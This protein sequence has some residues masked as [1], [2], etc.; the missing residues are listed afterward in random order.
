MDDQRGTRKRSCHDYGLLTAAGWEDCSCDSAWALLTALVFLGGKRVMYSGNGDF[1]W[2]PFRVLF[3]KK[4]W[5]QGSSKLCGF[6]SDTVSHFDKL[7]T[8]QDDAASSETW[9]ST[10]CERES[11]SFEVYQC[12]RH[13]I[14][15][16]M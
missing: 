16:D 9:W 7:I 13:S 3:K 12:H 10:V 15:C 14:L 1:C 5:S 6:E 11:E 8:E 4:G 2:E